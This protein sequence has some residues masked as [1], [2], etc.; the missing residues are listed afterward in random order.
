ME[1]MSKKNVWSVYHEF[2]DSTFCEHFKVIGFFPTREEARTVVRRLKMKPGFLD[3]QKGFFIGRPTLD[4]GSW[5]E[6]FHTMMGDTAMPEPEIPLGQL[7]V[8]DFAIGQSHDGL[9]HVLHSYVDQWNCTET[10]TIGLYSDLVLAKSAV[11]DRLK[12]PG[13]RSRPTG[14]EINPVTLGRVAYENGF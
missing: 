2:E 12:Q 5:E 7:T 4:G 14:F 13:F 11:K 9:W 8:L 3:Q 10:K 6:G 1:E